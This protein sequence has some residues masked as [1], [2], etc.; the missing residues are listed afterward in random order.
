MT[1][2]SKMAG[3]LE[4]SVAV[5]GLWDVTRVVTGAERYYAD[6]D[7]PTAKS[8]NEDCERWA[9]GALRHGASGPLSSLIKSA[10]T[11]ANVMIL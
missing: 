6:D 4:E 11:D 10:T 1:T 2:V 5:A 3:K 9:A 7:L 8:G